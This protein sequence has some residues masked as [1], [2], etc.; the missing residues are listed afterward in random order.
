V[1]EGGGNKGMAYVGALQV[2]SFD[3]FCSLTLL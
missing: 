1:F 3:L 2:R